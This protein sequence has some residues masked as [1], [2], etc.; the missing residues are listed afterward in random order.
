LVVGDIEIGT[1]VLVAGAGPAGYT[2]AIRCARLGLDVTLVNKNELGGVCLHRGCVPVK[3]LLYVYRLA[4]DCKN[5]SRM[6]LNVQGI[7]VDAKKA[8]DWKAS[9][10][11][12]LETGIRELCRESGVQLLEGACSFTSS[13]K[14]VVLG[15]SGTQYV[16][17][18]RAVIATG[19]SHKPLPGL[20]FDGK[21]IIHPDDAI[22]LGDEPEDIIMLGGGYGAITMAALL[23]AR[24][25][26][27]TI[28]HK[29][30]NVL[31][32]LD[33]DLVKPA[34][35]KFKEKGLKVYSSPS[36]TIK[37]SDDRIRVDFEHDGKKDF[38]EAGKLVPAIGLR[39]NTEGIGLEN[40]GVKAGK[41]GFIGTDENYRTADHA[42]Y[43]IGDVRSDHCN[44][45]MA[46]REGLSLA[47]ILAGRPG[48]PDY[49]ALPQSISTEPEIASAGFGEKDAKAAGLEA[50]TGRFPFAADGKAVSMGKTD[51]F[52]K[53]VAEK[54]S[55]RILGIHAVGPNAFDVLQ[56][57]VLAVEMGA[58]LEDVALTMHPH[59]TLCEAIK[60]ACAVALRTST[61]VMGK[62]P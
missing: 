22:A 62:M 6:G 40:T 53:V 57:G 56:E 42:F 9:V 26:R 2:L 39:A 18:K 44:A 24:G 27:L 54:E 29:G 43:A 33:A 37:K 3:T 52:V 47:E 1:D 32:F 8:N 19:S 12:R 38:A 41:D 46:F 13:S 34:L 7:S 36:W 61:N 49:I 60:E 25:K 28:I 31:S 10:V 4:E 5:A 20:P 11:H 30:E 48:L 17:F 45:T 55:H 58:R 16:E 51:G 23:A 14:A 15:P 35:D 59:P 21:Q 50:I